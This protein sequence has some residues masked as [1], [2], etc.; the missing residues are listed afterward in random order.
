MLQIFIDCCKFVKML[1][2]IKMF[3]LWFDLKHFVTFVNNC[4]MNV[5]KRYTN[6]IFAFSD[7]FPDW[8]TNAEFPVQNLENIW[9]HN[10]TAQ[11]PLEETILSPAEHLLGTR[12]ELDQFFPE[13]LNNLATPES[14]MNSL[15]SNMNSL[16]S[17]MN[18]SEANMFSTREELNH[19]F[20]EKFI[21]LATIESN[22]NLF[23]IDPFTS[24]DNYNIANGLDDLLVDTK[25]DAVGQN[26]SQIPNDFLDDVVTIA[27]TPENHTIPEPISDTIAVVPDVVPE[28][29]TSVPVPENHT[30]PEPISNITVVVPDVVSESP[31]SVPVPSVDTTK[32]SL[33]NSQVDPACLA[34]LENLEKFA[35]SNVE[36]NSRKRSL[37]VKVESN[38][39]TMKKRQSS[40]RS[41]DKRTVSDSVDERRIKN[42]AASRDYRA[43]K[44]ARHNKLFK[45]EKELLEENEVLKSKVQEL[46]REVTYLKNYVVNRLR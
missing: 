40:S 30:I 10:I 28:S 16:E 1:Q 42:N 4:N 23:N 6:R 11:E 32:T 7:I 12:E 46:T 26:A 8:N 20:M 22:I 5:L 36:S 33:H 13:E 38:D 37:E 25:D 19:S 35:K 45:Q 41:T 31:L 43:S 3:Q 29:P 18:S 44:K 15:E 39:P 27:P 9:E 17:N 24:L 21:D 14:N 34:L 2:I